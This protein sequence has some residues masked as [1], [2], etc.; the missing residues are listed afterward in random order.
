MEK[1]LYKKIDEYSLAYAANWVRFPKGIKDLKVS[2]WE[3]HEGEIKE[4]WYWF[5]S[6]EAAKEFFQIKI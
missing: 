2:D 6:E 1:G 5:N 4:G 3:N